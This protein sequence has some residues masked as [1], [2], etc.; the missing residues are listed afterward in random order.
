[1]NLKI[2]LRQNTNYITLQN[3]KILYTSSTDVGVWAAPKIWGSEMLP[4]LLSK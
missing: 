1:V 4:N 2:Y 3:Q